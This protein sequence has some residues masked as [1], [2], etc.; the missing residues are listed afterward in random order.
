MAKTGRRPKLTRT[1]HFPPLETFRGVC[2]APLL[3]RAKVSA[4]LLEL[5]HPA[6]PQ[7]PDCRAGL[8]GKAAERWARLEYVRCPQCARK[9]GWRHGTALDGTHVDPSQVL[10]MSIALEAGLGTQRVAAL[11]G[12]SVSSIRAW[13][14]RLPNNDREPEACLR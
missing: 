8:I 12:V 14:G 2:L 4:L 10:V 1:G 13:R 7:C 11:S 6:G 9:F 3:D 5:V